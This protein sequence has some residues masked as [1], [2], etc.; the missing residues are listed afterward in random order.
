MSCLWPADQTTDQTWRPTKL[1]IQ[2]SPTMLHFTVVSSI[3]S[4]CSLV[5]LSL[6]HSF[7]LFLPIL[8]MLSFC[9]L[10]SL[11]WVRC[12]QFIVTA[13][14]FTVVRISISFAFQYV[15]W[16]RMYSLIHKHSLRTNVSF[17][18]HGKCILFVVNMF[19]LN[20][21]IHNSHL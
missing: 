17:N 12:T 2:Y 8:S 7:T 9:S 6:S 18:N 13:L 16:K 11:H 15:A 21:P 5:Y 3:R 1:I 19:F 10:Y 4:L 20:V 14:Y